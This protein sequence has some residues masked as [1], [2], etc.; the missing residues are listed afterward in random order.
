MFFNTKNNKNALI[1]ILFITTSSLTISAQA[2]KPSNRIHNPGTHFYLNDDPAPLHSAV[3]ASN[4]KALQLLLKHG[5]DPDTEDKNGN[6]PLMV[7][8]ALGKIEMID[9]SLKHGADPASRNKKG[10]TFIPA[11]L[12]KDHPT[13]EILKI[14]DSPKIRSFIGTLPIE[15]RTEYLQILTT[16]AFADT[17]IDPLI[18]W[19]E[20][21]FGL[22]QP[23]LLSTNFDDLDPWRLK[24]LW[25]QE[26]LET[27]QAYMREKAWIGI[28]T[29]QGVSYGSI[30]KATRIYQEEHLET[31]FAYVTKEMADTIGLD[32]FSGLIF[33]GGG[34]NYPA[35]LDTFTLEDMP[36][37]EQ[38]E[39]E[40]VYQY[41]YE[42]ALATDIPTSG[43]CAG[44]QHLVLHRG[45]ALTH[46]KTH[47]KKVK[48][49]SHHVPHFLSLTLE[50]RQKLPE[51]CYA[52]DFS[53]N[54]FR[55]HKY[56]AVTETVLAAGLTLAMED[57]I[58]PPPYL[59]RR[60]S[61]NSHPVSS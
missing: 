54:I 38:T 21:Q 28:V 43:I 49:T 17:T 44:A 4:L 35:H 46:N 9:L 10:Q 34:D 15:E 47:T 18:I 56:S 61:N 60:V 8:S 23:N 16:R 5:I 51:T 14:L 11:T 42:Q 48:F 1:L 45:G 2:N 19:F 6:T 37:H 13:I 24:N 39:K 3:Q 7:A 31:Q 36:E 30:I 55:A 52:E 12:E 26:N 53:I 41:L 22:S 20:E 57:G 50:E 25:T 27:V 58:T 33:P 29:D 40:K 32:H 59:L